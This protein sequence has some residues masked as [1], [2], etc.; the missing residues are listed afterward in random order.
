MPESAKDR[1]TVSHEYILMLTKAAKCYWDQE[2][3]RLEYKQATIDR[4][5]G[6][7]VTTSDP[8]RQVG[9]KRVLASGA[10]IRSVWTFPTMPFPSTKI[11]GREL[12]HFAVFPEKLPELCIKA[13]TPEVG[14]CAECGAPCERIVEK[15]RAKPQRENWRYQ[16][17]V[18]GRSD[19]SEAGG[20]YDAETK[21]IGWRATCKCNAARVPS[22][23]LDSFAGAGT[24]L[25]VAKNLNRYAVGYEISG[26]YCQLA[27]ERCR[28]QVLL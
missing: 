2:A 12:E 16:K 25:L 7:Q 3:V 21:T 15:I 27:G 23:V 5:D 17:D 4:A 10:N 20:W 24:T 6:S 28:Q 14:C 26:E 9:F 8:D 1:P 19:Y 22:L 18:K 11:D 13:A